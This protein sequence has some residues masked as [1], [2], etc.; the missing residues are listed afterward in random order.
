MINQETKKLISDHFRSLPPVVQDIVLKSGWEEKI[1]RI[2]QNNKLHIDQGAAIENLVF[3]TMLGIEGAETFVQNAQEYARVSAT[4]AE[5]ISIE[6]EREIFHEIRQKLIEI[7]E[8]HDTIDEVERVTNELTKVDDDI[9]RAAAQST[10]TPS[11]TTK[12]STP[13]LLDEVTIPSKATN[14]NLKEQPAILALREMNAAAEKKSI[15]LTKTPVPS[16]KKTIP[17]TRPTD[18]SSNDVKSTSTKTSQTAA[19]SAQN[20]PRVIVTLKQ[21]VVDTKTASPNAID[22]QDVALP[23]AT[24]LTAPTSTTLTSSP[25]TSA[26]TA[27]TETDIAPKPP[28]AVFTPMPK[29]LDPIIAA[30]LGKPTASARDRLEME[31]SDSVLK[32][33]EEKTALADA[34]P[35][36][37]PQTKQYNNTDP[38]RETVA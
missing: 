38:Y 5:E 20:T 37:S 24:Q 17:L 31:V 15:E 6:V 13:E 19:V 36:M 29:S 28:V 27:P 3:L 18:V 4:Q 33:G 21:N 11:T 14:A 9:D 32:V 2:V 26:V 23:T 30:K 25:E 22:T 35:T 34:T 1:R 16:F 8:S 12:P 7:T 10:T